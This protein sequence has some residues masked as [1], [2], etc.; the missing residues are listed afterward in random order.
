MTLGTHGLPLRSAVIARRRRRLRLAAGSLGL[1]VVAFIGSVAWMA[2]PD[3]AE[4]LALVSQSFRK[5]APAADLPAADASMAAAPVA[6]SVSP[7]PV[8][9]HSIVPGG[10]YSQKDVAAAVGRDAVVAAHYQP[11]DLERLR[12]VTVTAARAVYVSYRR[13]NDVYWTKK[14]VM[15]APGETLLTDGT[16]EIRAR[17]GNRVSAHSQLP[18]AADEPAVTVLDTIEPEGDSSSMAEERTDGSGLTHV[19]FLHAWGESLGGNAPE[20]VVPN[21]GFP[22]GGGPLWSG[23]GSG[24]IPGV[25]PTDGSSG[26]PVTTL[27]GTV[28]GGAPFVP[29]GGPDETTTNGSTTT[30]GAGTTTGDTT[31]TTTGDA[32]TTTGD[33]GTTTGLVTTGYTVGDTTTDGSGDTDGEVPLVP[34]PTILTLL[35]LGAVAV[36]VRARRSRR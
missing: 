30:G 26:P 18:V 27:G 11:I 32:G 23:A 2:W 1:C 9:R 29:P 19:P 17:C 3:R 24:F 25:G 20:G 10:A 36:A 6:A 21:G 5:H 8:Y 28:R 14:P 35:G 7:R 12:P 33:T 31:G 22:L 34:E 13:G 16:S 15:L 4:I